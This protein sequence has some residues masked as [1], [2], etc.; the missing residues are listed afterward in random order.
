MIAELT[1]RP[2]VPNL[3]TVEELDENGQFE[4][5]IL[6]E[7]GEYKSLIPTDLL[8]CAIISKVKTVA[9]KTV[10]VLSYGF[11]GLYFDHKFETV[12]SPFSGTS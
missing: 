5:S 9:V 4:V 6:K 1:D 7:Q 8:F 10:L 12:L 2:G 3:T 11:K